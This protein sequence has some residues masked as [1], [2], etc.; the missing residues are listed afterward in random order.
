MRIALGHV[1]PLPY[2]AVNHLGRLTEALVQALGLGDDVDED[3][4]REILGGCDCNGE[5][6]S[7]HLLWHLVS[8]RDDLAARLAAAHKCPP[9]ETR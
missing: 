6:G 3:T 8:Q 7:L 4:A 2:R 9:K 1:C 5:E